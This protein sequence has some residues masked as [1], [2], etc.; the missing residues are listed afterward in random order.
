MVV[1]WEVA[2]LLESVTALTVVMFPKVQILVDNGGE[3]STWHGLSY[4]PSGSLRSRR[5]K[6]VDTSGYGRNYK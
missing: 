4:C 5:Q 3:K 6:K 2:A 1:V